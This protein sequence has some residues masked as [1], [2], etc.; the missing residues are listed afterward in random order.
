MPPFRYSLGRY[1][2]LLS[3]YNSIITAPER[4]VKSCFAAGEERFFG[5]SDGPGLQ[6]A[7]LRG[8]LTFQLGQPLVELSVRR[9]LFLNDFA[10]AAKPVVHFVAE[11]MYRGA[12]RRK[13]TS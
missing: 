2:V 6:A 8:S 7:N 5:G 13:H 3:K 9:M 11:L 4:T 10:N 12:H 1:I